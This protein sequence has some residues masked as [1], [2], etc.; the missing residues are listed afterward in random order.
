MKQITLLLATLLTSTLSAQIT[1]LLT[2]VDFEFTP[3]TIYAAQGDSL[4]IVFVSTEHTFTQVTEATW[5][6]NGDTPSGGWNIG[7][8]LSEATIG[9]DG[10]GTIHYVCLPHAAMGMK[11]V[12]IVSIQ[13]AIAE[14]NALLQER[15]YPNPTGGQLWLRDMPNGMADLFFLDASGRE[16]L[17]TQVHGN[18]PL[19]VS[20]LPIGLYTVRAVGS[21]GQEL[22]R[23]RLMK[24]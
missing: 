7:P 20:Q 15:F 13:S 14:R 10:S 11:G 22:F 2:A 6:T 17:R 4:H 5:D 8:G 19:D 16:V 1:H 3:D 9:L 12:V 23:Q 21:A 18:L 24:Q